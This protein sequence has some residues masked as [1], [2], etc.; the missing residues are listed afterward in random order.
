MSNHNKIHQDAL[1]LNSKFNSIKTNHGLLYQ[2]GREINLPYADWVAHE[3]GFMF[4]EG[5]VKYLE[6]RK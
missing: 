3:F 1:D 6:K 2:Y 5:L 4:A